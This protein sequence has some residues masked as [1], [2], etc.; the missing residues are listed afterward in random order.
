VISF[1]M[2]TGWSY[3][4]RMSGGRLATTCTGWHVA[5]RPS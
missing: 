3:S 5:A 4:A 1:P 2:P